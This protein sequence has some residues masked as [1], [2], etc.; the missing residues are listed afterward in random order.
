MSNS[1]QGIDQ[2]ATADY[3][4]LKQFAERFEDAWQN[5]QRPVLE[6]FLPTGEPERRAVLAE[7][8]YIDLERRLKAGETAR[9]EDYL[10]RFPELAAHPELAQGLRAV[11][12]KFRCREGD[13]T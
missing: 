12:S 10:Q 8:V 5:G 4:R 11:E 2:L 9:A 13:V 3:V 1:N 6:E 7:L